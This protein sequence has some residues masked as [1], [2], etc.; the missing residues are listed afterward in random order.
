MY[1]P[2]SILENETQKIIYDFEV[3]MD[4]LYLG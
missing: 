1:K 3:Q 4:H 2:E